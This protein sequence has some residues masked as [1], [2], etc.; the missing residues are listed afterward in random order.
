MYGDRELSTWSGP[1]DVHPTAKAVQEL[2]R[3]AVRT[4]GNAPLTALE[5]DRHLRGER[6]EPTLIVPVKARRR[7]AAEAAIG[8]ARETEP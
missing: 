1:R 5:N 6:A 4:C 8:E 3:P 2:T 7:E